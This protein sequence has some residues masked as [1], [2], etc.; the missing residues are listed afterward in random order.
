MYL[1]ENRLFKFNAKL[2]NESYHLS[3][4]QLKLLNRSF[5]KLSSFGKV[6]IILKVISEKQNFLEIGRLKQTKAL[7]VIN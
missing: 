6:S 3:F 2:F 4:Y 1:V 7:L 5:D